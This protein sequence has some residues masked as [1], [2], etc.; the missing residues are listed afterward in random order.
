ME[1]KEVL[2]VILMQTMVIQ[3]HITSL[4][5]QDLISTAKDLVWAMDNNEAWVKMIV[6]PASRP[7]VVPAACLRLAVSFEII[8]TIILFI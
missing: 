5:S 3:I 8:S 7:D 6:V 4:I 2:I 1:I